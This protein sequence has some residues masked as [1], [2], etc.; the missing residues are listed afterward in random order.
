LDED[1]EIATTLKDILD[2]GYPSYGVEGAALTAYA[3][4]GQKDAVAVITPWLSK[5]SHQDTLADAAL[6][7]L[8]A[9]G[10]PAV[11]DTLLKW[12]IPERSR[13]RRAAALRGLAQLAKSKRLTD[14]QRQQIIKP[15]LT[16][17]ESD[18]FLSRIA[19]LQALPELGSL[20][21]VALPILDKMAQEQ[22]RGG[23]VRQIKAAADRIRA[24]TGA[25]AATTDASELNRLRE[26]VK[27][28]ERSQE[29]LRK[30]LDKFESGKK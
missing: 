25:S 9:T 22:S 7:A 14:E 16:A 23:F 6:T 15:L 30:R 20:A 4:Q 2:K 13:T 11:L 10:D 17:L 27:R 3:R 24:Q 19:A 29:E 26:E 8:G 28:L 18:D 5:E 21:S 1:A 12:N